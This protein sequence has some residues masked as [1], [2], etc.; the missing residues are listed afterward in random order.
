MREIDGIL[1]FLEDY[2]LFRPSNEADLDPRVRSITP[3][4]QIVEV[5][6]EA[7]VL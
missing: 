2:G 6:W 4:E 1:D 7:L 5:D 3:D